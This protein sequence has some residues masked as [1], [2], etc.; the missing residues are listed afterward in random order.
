MWILTALLLGAAV[1]VAWLADD[2]PQA[3]QAQGQTTQAAVAQPV[4]TGPIDASTFRTIAERVTPAV[5]SVRTE[6]ARPRQYWQDMPDELWQ[7][8]DFPGAPHERPRGPAPDP[9]GERLEGAGSGFVIDASG[10]IM[11]NNH[12]VEGASRIEVGLYSAAQSGAPDEP[13]REAKVVGRDPLTDTALIRLTSLPETPLTVSTLGNSEVMAPGDWVIAIGNPFNLAHTVTVG[14]VS[15]EG[16]PFANIPGRQQRLLQTDAAINP[17]NSGGPLLNLRGEVIGINTAIFS[18]G[19]QPG[20]LG[21]GFAV[22]IDTVKAL[23]PQLREGKVTRGRIGVQVTAV[24]PEA[25]NA[26]GVEAR[27]GALASIVERGGPAAQAGMQAGDVVV[28]FDGKPVENTEQLV[29]MVVGT[30]PGKTV[31]VQVIRAGKPVTLNVTVAELDFTA[32]GNQAG[33]ETTGGWG[34]TLS[35]SEAGQTASGPVVTSVDARS[36]A[37]RAGIRRGD[38]LLEVNRETVRNA[39][40]A[41]AAFRNAASGQVATVLLSR[42]GQQVFVTLVKSTQS[43]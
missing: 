27:R 16:R 17:G 38:I 40:D 13:L 30:A 28:S 5:V 32:G 37:A 6:S 12:V 42:N 15:A 36:P 26:L 20:N 8:F 4:A 9:N 41:R 14:V 34:V 1:L 7:F 24:P 2:D 3:V 19:R 25:A 11:T 39:A 43:K 22:P 21:I 33:D 31:P 29:Q 35:D 10:L 23:L 18:T